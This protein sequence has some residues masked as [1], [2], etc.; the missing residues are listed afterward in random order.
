MAP[1]SRHP[2]RRP[3][4]LL[5]KVWYRYIDG[6]DRVVIFVGTLAGAPVEP[7]SDGITVRQATGDDVAAL[8]LL[9]ANPGTRRIPRLLSVGDGWLHVARHDN[10]LVG[11]RCAMRRFTGPSWLSGVV[12]LETT[13]VYI[14]HIFVDPEYR[15]HNI[16]QRISDAQNLD[17]LAMG[18]HQHLS[19]VRANNVPA[20]RLTLLRGARPVLYVDSRRRWFVH[21]R[22]VTS[23]MPPRVQRLVDGRPASGLLQ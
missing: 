3:G 11:Y 6:R 10:R 4:G 18:I 15:R 14:D 1:P 2:Q 23:V 5:G 8:R 22:T 19:V 7:G 21:R 20:L 17:L 13:Q 12:R 16:A 9:A